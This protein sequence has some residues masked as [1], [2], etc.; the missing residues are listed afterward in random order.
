MTKKAPKPKPSKAAIRERLGAEPIPLL[1]QCEIIAAFLA[2]YPKADREALEQTI[3]A[4]GLESVAR[5]ASNTLVHRPI[6]ERVGREAGAKL[7]GA[8]V[9][10]Y[11]NDRL[12]NGEPRATVAKSLGMTIA[13]FDQA[14]ARHRRLVK[15]A[16]SSFHE[17]AEP[18]KPKPTK[19]SA[20]PKRRV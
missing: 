3:A 19:A 17:T 4:E 16:E 5:A 18:E 12:R 11:A 14:I 10:E 6:D 9:F 15:R 20:R 13:A 7:R 2:K 1:D 8:F